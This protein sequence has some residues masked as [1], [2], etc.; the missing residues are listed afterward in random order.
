MLQVSRHGRE[1]IRSCFRSRLRV[2]GDLVYIKLTLAYVE[3]GRVEVVDGIKSILLNYVHL[4]SLLCSILFR[5]PQF[6]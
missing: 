6:S 4:I 2:S 5:G 1:R 3:A